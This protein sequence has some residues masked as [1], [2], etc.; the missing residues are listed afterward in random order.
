[1]SRKPSSPESTTAGSSIRNRF[2]LPW[3]CGAAILTDLQDQ[4]SADEAQRELTE[5]LTEIRANTADIAAHLTKAEGI[6]VSPDALGSA[7]L[8]LAEAQ[9]RKQV[10]DRYIY[11]DFKGIE[12]M[13]K[14]IPLKLDDV[15][16]D[17][18]V[19][20]ET[21]AGRGDQKQTELLDRLP[22]ADVDERQRL[23]AHLAELDAGKLRDAKHQGDTMPID[24]ALAKPG[25]VVLLG[26][27]PHPEATPEPW[28]AAV[29]REARAPR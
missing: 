17:L 2:A 13:E 19:Q 12:Q 6:D 8:Q 21:P 23:E 4:L 7:A 22:E 27:S 1:M 10:A 25:G 11:A 5:V 24:R 3:R 16:V 26:E 15:F 20:R 9:Y 14:L 29:D 18:R 28:T